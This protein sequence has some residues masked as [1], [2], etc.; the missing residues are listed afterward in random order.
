MSAHFV[1][2]S[3]NVW[4][5]ILHAPSTRD[6]VVIFTDSFREFLP[7]ALISLAIALG[8]LIVAA[9]IVKMGECCTDS[10]SS[11][12][13][14][15]TLGVN[16]KIIKWHE[17]TTFHKN[18]IKR[19]VMFGLA[20]FTSIFSFWIAAQA[21]GVNFWTIVLSYGILGLVATYAFGGPIKDMG[22]FLLISITN[23]VEEDWWVEVVGLGVQGQITAIHFL[24]I[25]LVYKDVETGQLEEAQIPTGYFLASVIKRKFAYEIKMHNRD[26]TPSTK[27]L[28]DEELRKDMEQTSNQQTVLLRHKHGLRYQNNNKKLEHV[29]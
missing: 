5:A 2:P 28:S 25:E 14:E 20:M 8:G 9:I 16:N 11:K 6:G 4:Y 3:N 29:V 7:T 24:W 12:H 15:K 18:A 27:E 26:L 21:M 22:A 19:T 13:W 17:S 10:R 23:K 1:D